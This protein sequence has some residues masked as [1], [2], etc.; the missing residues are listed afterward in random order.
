M[1]TQFKLF[2]PEKYAEAEA[3][4]NQYAEENGLLIK[5]V[6]VTLLSNGALLAAAVFEE[7]TADCVI[8]DKSEILNT[9]TDLTKSTIT[10]DAKEVFVKKS[11]GEVLVKTMFDCKQY[12]AKGIGY[13][14][15]MAHIL[16]QISESN[17][18][19]NILVKSISSGNILFIY[20]QG[21]GLVVNESNN[22][23]A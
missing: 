14:E 9:N 6:S 20:S 16:R 23:I 1:K 13:S 5:S 4:I 3:D 22:T 18:M 17:G 19:C 12:K 7:D 21:N 10:I 2:K 15:A 11:E 8:K